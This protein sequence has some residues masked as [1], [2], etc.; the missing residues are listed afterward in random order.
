MTTALAPLSSVSWRVLRGSLLWLNRLVSMD[1]SAMMAARRGLRRRS[2]IPGL[3]STARLTVMV[4]YLTRM[5]LAAFA[6]GVVIIACTFFGV[7]LFA[8]VA[9]AESVTLAMWIWGKVR[10]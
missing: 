10:N 2:W 5:S 9:A 4:F 6:T 3:M 7:T 8:F 1:L